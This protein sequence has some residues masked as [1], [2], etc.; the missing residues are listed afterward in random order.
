MGLFDIFKS[1][2]TESTFPENELEKCLIQAASDF[3][4]QK[5]FYQKLL[6]NQLFILT[7]ENSISKLKI[8]L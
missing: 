5:Q 8:K 1:K 4:A 6:W 3:S 7:S 2:K